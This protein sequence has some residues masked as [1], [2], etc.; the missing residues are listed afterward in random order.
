MT[1]RD[2]VVILGPRFHLGIVM[3]Y[4]FG[5][6]VLAVAVVAALFLV[7][8]ENGRPLLDHERAQGLVRDTVQAVAPDRSGWVEGDGAPVLYRWRDGSGNWQYGD[9]PPPGVR[10]EPVEE[11]KVKT[12]S[13]TEPL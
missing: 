12:V 4:L 1:S 8:V 13:G 7:P 11:R 10:A 5:I 6:V 9:V 3:K 2:M